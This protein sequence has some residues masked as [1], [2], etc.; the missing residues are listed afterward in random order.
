MKNLIYSILF[1]FAAY[2][3]AYSQVSIGFEGRNL[4][5]GNGIGV[6]TTFATSRTQ[7]TIITFPNPC[8][9]LVLRAVVDTVATFVW[10]T[11]AITDTTIVANSGTYS[12]TVTYP[13]GSTAIASIAA[14]VTTPPATPCPFNYTVDCAVRRINF[15]FPTG[16]T[17]YDPLTYNYTWAANGIVFATSTAGAAVAPPV[18]NMPVGGNC[19]DVFT[20]CVIQSLP[21]SVCT[22]RYCIDITPNCFAPVVTYNL[23]CANNLKVTDVSGYPSTATFNWVLR[24][25]N[26]SLPIFY[27]SNAH[28]G[29]ILQSNLTAG[30]WQL[31]LDLPNVPTNCQGV[32]TMITVGNSNAPTV[33]LGGATTVCC[34]RVN[35]IMASSNSAAGVTYLWSNGAT[36]AVLTLPANS[37]PCA[38]ITT[39][40]VTVTNVVGCTATATV[41]I[42][43]TMPATAAIAVTGN[44]CPKTLT[45][46][47]GGTYLWSS[48]ERTTVISATISGTYTVT[49]TNAAGCTA[50]ATAT[51]DCCNLQITE[52]RNLI[53]VHAQAVT[54]PTPTVTGCA[55]GSVLSY[56]WEFGDGTTS[57]VA[58]PTKTY[59]NTGVY[60]VCLTVTCTAAAGGTY[61]RAKCCRDVN[62]GKNCPTLYP[63]FGVNMPATGLSCT[64]TGT[65]QSTNVVPP[66]TSTYEIYNS[67]NVFVTSVAGTNVT[68]TFPNSG[69]YTVCRN[70]TSI[71][72]VNYGMYCI[73]KNCRKLTIIPTTG[74]NVAAKFVATTY[75]TNPLNVTFNASS[76]STGASSYY[77]EYSTS[78]T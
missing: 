59:T 29:D 10:S 77:W 26:A 58:S 15:S 16:S 8:G 72:D 21:G 1:F 50:T 40:T 45:A 74:C 19:N 32:C 23:D 55:T 6:E 37:L 44:T 42:T 3:Q 73:T 9:G 47:G 34:N 46:T 39:F 27:C 52:M 24:P 60:N 11:G 71:S 68:Y 61:C 25:C 70:L 5:T 78:P 49:I 64:F 53:Y 18:F 38:S 17:C 69:D 51:V 31:C 28:L 66:P 12:V 13:D 35:T 62:I 20:I 41:A 56:L 57:T 22:A 4:T 76:Y 14:T 54:F 36:T 65:I 7:P 75:K 48:G 43:T 30:C 63:T 2:S 67:T 33:T